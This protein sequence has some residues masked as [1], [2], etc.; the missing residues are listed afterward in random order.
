[1]KKL[2]AVLTCLLLLCA[3]IPVGAVSVSAKSPTPL[4]SETARLSDTSRAIASGATGECAW[5]LEKNILTIYGEGAMGDYTYEPTPWGQSISSVIIKNGVTTIG[6]HAFDNCEDLTNVEIPDSVVSIGKSAFF[7]CSSLASIRLPGSITT[8]KDRAFSACYGLKSISYSGSRLTRDQIDIG[9]YNDRF[10]EA[11]WHYCYSSNPNCFTGTTGDCVWTLEDTHLTISGKGKMGNYGYESDSE[12]APFIHAPWGLNISSLT[13][14]YGV[15]SIGDRAFE[16]CTA[17]TS[18]TIADSVTSVGFRSFDGC[19]ALS[20]ITFPDSVTAIS[21]AVL[22]GTAYYNDP[23]NWENNVLYAGNHLM[24]AKIGV[25]GDCIIREGTVC[26]ADSAFSMCSELTSVQIPDSVVYIGTKAFQRCEQLVSVTIPGGVKEISQSAFEDC[27]AL[28]TATISEGVNIIGH[29]AFSWCPS[30]TS[31]VIPDSVSRIAEFAFVCCSALSDISLPDSVIYIGM[32]AF[33][34]TAYYNDET[35]WTDGLLY[36]G[37]HLIKAKQETYGNCAVRE[38]TLTIADHAFFGSQIASVTIPDGT[39]VIGNSAFYDCAQLESITLPDTLIYIG[40][41]A[42]ENNAYYRNAANWE[43]DVLYIGKHLIAAK[44]NSV[45]GSYAIKDGTLTMANGAFTYCPKLI[46]VIIPDS[47]TAIGD[48]TFQECSALTAVVIPKSVISIGDG[49]FDSCTSLTNVYYTGSRKADRENIKI[50]SHNEALSDIFWD[51]GYTTSDT[52]GNWQWRLDGTHL[53]ISGKGKM[54]SYGYDEGHFIGAPWG[55]VITSVTIE[56]G[57]TNI[58]SYAFYQCAALTTVIIPDSV[59]SVESEAFVGCAALSNI[60]FSNSVT[61][62]A[63]GVLKDTSFYNNTA[64]WEN[65]VLYAG[66]HIIEARNTL[67]GGYAVRNGTISI[68]DRAFHCDNLTSVTIPNSVIAIGYEAFSDCDNL[69][70]VVVSANIREIRGRAFENCSALSTIVLPDHVIQ[71]GWRVFENTA[72]YNDKTNWIDGILYVGN[73]LVDSNNDISDECIVRDGTL[74]I[75]ESAFSSRDICSVTIPNSVAFIGKNAFDWCTD[76]ISVTLGNGIKTLEDELFHEC[77]SLVSI[78]IPEGVI[79]IGENVFGWCD[80][81]T[82]VSLPNSIATI[83]DWA[84]TACERLTDIYYSGSEAD[85]ANITIGSDNDPLL[86]ATWH[87]TMTCDHT[88]VGAITTPNN[89]GNAGVMTYTCT[90]CG[91]TYTEV[92]PPVGDHVYDNGFD[93]DCNVCGDVRPVDVPDDA[94]TFVVEDATAREGD[95]FTVA[96]R[97]LNNSGIVSLKLKVA[98]DAD[99]LE[100]ISTAQGDFAEPTFGP[101]VKN[102][103]TV[104]WLETLLPNNTTDGAV[105]FLTFRVKEGA[106][107]GETAITITYDPEDVYDSNFDNVSFLVENGTVNVVDFLYG[108]TNGDGNVNNKDLGLLQRYINEWD[109]T[110]DTSAADVDG[111]GKVNNLDLGLLQRYLSDW[112]VELG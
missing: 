100:L 36:I 33:E 72:Y 82:S 11:E 15:T 13:I 88:Y 9:E 85:R 14:E 22:R 90:A 106:T 37:N 111:N 48:A 78:T 101:I 69:T 84:F 60:T 62:I 53:T 108:D 56:N 95:I 26:I 44:S 99:V 46:S 2:F 94:P 24:E 109:V 77:W 96:I 6:D 102:P 52:V 10:Y 98:Y 63:A 3:S 12:N 75:A 17:L 91:D 16:D 107:I 112:D 30:L 93:A 38:G 58:G 86:S 74:S 105:A 18:V 27:S 104:N 43:N 1:M 45:S 87:Y 19:T 103:F 50:G 66:N 7:G 57:V 76:L 8:I 42:F 49:A 21:T 51:Y 54:G 61:S 64:N 31:I 28:T 20:S 29:S 34:E 81:L 23:N 83:G 55:T 92:L 71:I 97:T 35:Q 41:T 5:I 47:I 40:K 67:S 32:D 80:Q 4:S 79:S 39:M 110:L 65:G 70:S 89:C 59:T 73:H 25:S 68:A